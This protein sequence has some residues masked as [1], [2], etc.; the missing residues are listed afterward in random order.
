MLPAPLSRFIVFSVRMF[1]CSEFPYM[2]V[3]QSLYLIFFLIV[4]QYFATHINLL[5]GKNSSDNP[6]S[7]ILDIIANYERRY[8]MGIL[9]MGARMLSRTSPAGLALAG[10]ALVM[11]VP[12]VRRQVKAT[13]AFALRGL[14]SMV[15]E[16]RM[17]SE[18]E[19]ESA[20]SPRQERWRNKLHQVR[21]RSRESARRAAIGTA[22]S[23]M[24]AS[25]RAKEL[26]NGM[27]DEIRNIVDEAKSSRIRTDSADMSILPDYD[28]VPDDLEGPPRHDKGL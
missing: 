22:A 7:S 25:D 6:F 12:A 23:M 3:L 14:L 1:I 18:M 2:L 26:Y 9:S 13:T 21:D 27:T 10:A 16:D 4:N 15:E 24:D 8:M 5:A 19:D 28:P 17:E 11:T 20:F